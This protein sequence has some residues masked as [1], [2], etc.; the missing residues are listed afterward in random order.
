MVASKFSDNGS[1]GSL[2]SARPFLVAAT[3][4]GGPAVEAG[5]HP[6]CFE[7]FACTARL[8]LAACNCG[9]GTRQR[10]RDALQKAEKALDPGRKAEILGETFDGLLQDGPAA[11]EADIPEDGLEA[12]QTFLALAISIGAPA[13]NLGDRRGCSEVYACTAR[14]LLEMVEGANEARLRL[15]QALEECAGSSDADARAW[16]LRHAFDDIGKMRSKRPMSPD[17]MRLYL[18]LAIRIGAPAY[19]TGDQLGCYEVYACTARLVVHT[20]EGDEE[21]RQLLRQALERCSLVTD[22]NARAWIMRKAFDSILGEEQE[23][24]DAEDEDLEV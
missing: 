2:G 18:A 17:E 10:L 4:L 7:L 6:G 5:D 8:A 22:V 13:Y 19:N 11:L 21:A 20:L 1:P 23:E 16:T 3:R 24:E 15:Q 14:M 9:D 12:I